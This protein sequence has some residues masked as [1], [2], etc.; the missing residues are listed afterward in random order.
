MADQAIDDIQKDRSCSLRGHAVLQDPRFNKGTA[1]SRSE[2]DAFGLNGLLPSGINTLERQAERAYRQYQ[3]YESP[4][5]KNTF[6]TSLKDQ[7]EV[8]YYRVIQDHIKEMMPI[9][10]TPTEGDAIARYSHIFRRPEGCFLNIEE[11]GAIESS[12]ADAA[13][14]RGDVRIIVCSDGEQILGL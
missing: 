9:I 14:S 5:A 13:T 4:L 6:M 1:F 8:L 7:N 11:A 2:R 12:L 10:Y 3:S